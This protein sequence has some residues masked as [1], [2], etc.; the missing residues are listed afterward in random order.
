MGGQSPEIVDSAP[1]ND[2]SHPTHF[3][4]EPSDEL[5]WR[6]H[7]GQENGRATP[8][9]T[10]GESNPAERSALG[11]AGVR[12]MATWAIV[13]KPESPACPHSA[14]HHDLYPCDQP[15]RHR[16]CGVAV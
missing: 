9:P 14:H 4:R 8:G 7:D 12:L 16:R 6:H 3:K 10:A 5:G 13:G 11:R 1:G 2:E 15:D